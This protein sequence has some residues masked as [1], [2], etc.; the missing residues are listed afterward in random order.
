LDKVVQ[1]VEEFGDGWVFV[2]QRESESVV[3]LME[4]EHKVNKL[5]KSDN[6]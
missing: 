3:S 4:M 6:T 5:R 1:I 2:S